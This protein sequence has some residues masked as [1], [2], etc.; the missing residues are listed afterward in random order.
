MYVSTIYNL[1]FLCW[2]LADSRQKST[3]SSS[4]QATP[5]TPKG[6]P[7]RTTKNKAQKLS[8]GEEEEKDTSFESPLRYHSYTT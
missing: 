1:L 3:R 8:S 6:T 2:Y 4:A 7:N 5:K